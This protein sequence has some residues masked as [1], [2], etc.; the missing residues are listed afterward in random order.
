MKFMRRIVLTLFVLLGLAVAPTA[1]FAQEEMP[2]L[3]IACGSLSDEDCTF[4]KESRA[5]VQSLSSSASTLDMEIS[6]ANLPGLPADL[7]M[8]ISTDGRFGMD[9]ELTAKMAALQL[10][11]PED[12]EE[13]V[14]ELMGMVVDFYNSLQ[15]DMTVDV[16]LSDGITSLARAGGAVMPSALQLPMRMVDGVFYM[17][18]DNMA[19][20]PGMEGIGGWIGVEIAKLIAD[21]LEQALA[22]IESGA[23]AGSPLDMSM[24]GASMGMNSAMSEAVNRFTSV[25]RLEDSTLD[26]VDVAQFVWNFDLGGYLGSPEFSEMLM[27]QLETQ[28]E[29]A[30][31][32][33]QPMPVSKSD[34]QMITDMLPMLAPMLLAEAQFETVASI[35]LE[36]QYVYETGTTILFDTASVLEMASAMQL[37]VPAELLEADA[38]VFSLTTQATNGDFNEDP[39]VEAP[40]DAILVPLDEMQPMTTM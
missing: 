3:P 8:Q 1:V 22:G 23:M 24:M 11:K 29:M 15:F 37:G 16:G 21:S 32:M 5:A 13:M 30:E 17:N 19:S 10:A 14:V 4:L 9:P 2:E 18:F 35:G 26:G 7:S 20:L 6:L 28:M 34:V 31:A 25:E 36:D 39:A 38:P 33:G 40:E 12:V 27:T